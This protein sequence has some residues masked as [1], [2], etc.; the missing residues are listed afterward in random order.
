MKLKWCGWKW[1]CWC[2]DKRWRTWLAKMEENVNETSL[3]D[4]LDWLKWIPVINNNTNW[5]R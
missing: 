4:L 2:I 1:C 3:L 5:K